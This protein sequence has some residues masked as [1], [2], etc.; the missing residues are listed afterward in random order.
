[1]VQGA[2]TQASA[3]SPA[4]SPPTKATHKEAAN[5][6]FYTGPGNTQ[7]ARIQI[8]T[9]EELLDGKKLDMPAL[10][11]LRTFTKAPKAKGKRGKEAELF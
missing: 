6:G 4:S 5:A 1:M 3:C 2:E 9:V 8:L 7:H 11:D 10:R